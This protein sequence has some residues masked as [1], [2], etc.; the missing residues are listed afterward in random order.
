MKINL[1]PA[2]TPSWFVDDK[3]VFGASTQRGDKKL[4]KFANKL[5]VTWTLHPRGIYSDYSRI[6]S[7][8]F[9]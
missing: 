3:E 7:I 8:K 9:G 6:T 4:R 5:P 1:F 2:I